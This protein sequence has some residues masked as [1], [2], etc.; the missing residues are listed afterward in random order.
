M[1]FPQHQRISFIGHLGTPSAPKEI[2]T[3]RLNMMGVNT[4]TKS[5]LD[6]L[7]AAKA[8][9]IAHIKDNVM[10]SVQ[11]THI[12]FAHINPDGKY[13]AEPTVLDAPVGT[14]NMVGSALPWQ[15]ALAVTLDTPRRGPTGKGRIFL[16]VPNVGSISLSDGSFDA[17]K[18]STIASA[19]KGLVQAL[20]DVDPNEGAVAIVSSK[21]Y[22]SP[23][24]SVRCGRILDTIRTRRNDLVEAYS[25][26]VAITGNTVFDAD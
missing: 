19:V 11:L 25:A 15:T 4:A 10:S 6:Y 20:N 2:W 16:P 1:V 13:G 14:T 3:F 23:V 17:L 8:A 12:K 21:G 7:N 18:A 22:A 9:Y 24:T 26:P 5:P